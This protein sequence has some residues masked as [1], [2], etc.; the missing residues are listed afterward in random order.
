MELITINNPFQRHL[1]EINVL[2][3]EGQT[4]EEILQAYFEHLMTQHSFEISIPE[5][6]DLVN[7]S[8]NGNLIPSSFWSNTTPLANDQITIIPVVGKGDTEKQLINIAIIIA[9]VII[10]G[11]TAGTYVQGLGFSA[12]TA[13]T[14]GTALVAVGTGMLIQSL[15]PSPGS[16]SP[17]SQDWESSQSFS[18]NPTTTQRQG[19]I[20]PKFY[21]KNKKP[22]NCI[23][24]RRSIADYLAKAVLL[25]EIKPK[26]KKKPAPAQTGKAPAKPKKRTTKKPTS[27]K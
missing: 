3:F 22:T 18:W 20:I 13:A 17:N 24:C 19:S 5:I 4:L 1:K 27:N 14:I 10:L 25:L 16:K 11:P 26:A 7:V 12:A 15:A 9:A 23:Y 21:G 2:E 6:K 8:I